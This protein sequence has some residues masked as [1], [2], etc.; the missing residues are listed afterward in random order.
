MY[1]YHTDLR[2]SSTVGGECSLLLHG[3]AP[4]LFVGREAIAQPNETLSPRQG[5]TL[6]TEHLR[7]RGMASGRAS[8]LH[9]PL[10]KKKETDTDTLKLL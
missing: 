8:P 5:R 6:E 9:Q 3:G 1:E 7:R 10:R 2:L 4:A